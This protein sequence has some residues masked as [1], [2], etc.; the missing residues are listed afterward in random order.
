MI[1]FFDRINWDNIVGNIR[2]VLVKLMLEKIEFF[3]LLKNDCLS[4]IARNRKKS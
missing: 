3:N 4:R 1:T 2:K